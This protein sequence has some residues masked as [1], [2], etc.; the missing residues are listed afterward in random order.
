MVREFYLEDPSRKVL[1]VRPRPERSV[2]MG[3]SPDFE[4]VV[5]KELLRRGIPREAV[6]VVPGVART[7]WDECRC[8]A[9]WFGEHP[10]D[11]IC[12]LSDRFGSGTMRLVLRQS[13]GPDVAARVRIVSLANP[14]YDEASWWKDR[15]GVKDFMAAWLVNIYIRCRGEDTVRDDNWDPDEYERS[16]QGEAGG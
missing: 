14:R 5:R 7:F 4:T 13:A 10:A 2:R 11:S 16:I 6:V 12:L 3:A 1:V 9:A 8:L 15:S